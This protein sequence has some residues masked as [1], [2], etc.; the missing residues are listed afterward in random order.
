MVGIL[1]EPA[2]GG[3]IELETGG[4]DD[5]EAQPCH[6]D[7]TEHVAM[8][9]REHAT[10]HRRA[11]ADELEGAGVDLGRSLTARAAILEDL[12]A[13]TLCLNFL[14][15]DAFVLAVVELAEKRR[16]LRIGE[17]GDLGCPHGPL[18][19]AGVDGIEAQTAQPRSQRPGLGFALWQEW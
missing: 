1:T 15:G 4:D 12:P 2:Q 17:A 7:G 19:G 5:V 16:Q 18:K 9:E 3:Y 10:V 11:Q 6:P 8:S 13:W 14:G